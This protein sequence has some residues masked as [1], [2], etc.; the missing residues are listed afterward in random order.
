MVDRLCRRL[1][2]SLI[3][4][5]ILSAIAIVPPAGHA[6]GQ[7]PP[8]AF[9]EYVNTSGRAL[10]ILEGASGQPVRFGDEPWVIKPGERFFS[11]PWGDAPRFRWGDK[12]FHYLG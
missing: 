1:C 12:S 7:T 8:R 4:L 2:A 5:V 10:P 3:C 6:Q 11:L 9:P